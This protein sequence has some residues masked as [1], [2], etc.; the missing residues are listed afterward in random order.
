MRDHT[1]L[2]LM[3]MAI[4]KEDIF[5]TSNKMNSIFF[6]ILP[7]CSPETSAWLGN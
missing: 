1:I 5:V 2:S 4:I 7:S 6:N 3:S